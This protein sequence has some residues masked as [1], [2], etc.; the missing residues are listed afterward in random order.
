MEAHLTGKPRA[1]CA[2]RVVTLGQP[3]RSAAWTPRW[4]GKFV[5]VEAT[6]ANR[7]SE[8]SCARLEESHL[9]GCVMVYPLSTGIYH[10]PTAIYHMV[11]TIIVW[12]IS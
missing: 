8:I 12:Y 6:L 1:G 9:E 7:K 3:E 10:G 4:E 11:Y 5:Q 2:S